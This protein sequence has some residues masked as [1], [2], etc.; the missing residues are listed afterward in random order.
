MTGALKRLTESKASLEAALR[1]VA[2]PSLGVSRARWLL[3]NVEPPAIIDAL[4]RGTLP[5]GLPDPTTEVTSQ[6]I[7]RW[8]TGLR[9][10]DAAQ[11]TAR[12]ADRCQVIIDAGHDAWPFAD[13]PDPPVLLFVRGRVELLTESRRV[14]VVGTRRCSAVGRSVAGEIGWTL[15]EHGISVVSGLALGIDGS[16]HRGAGVSPRDPG[17]IGVVASGLDMV[18]PARNAALWAGVAD[19]GVL[20]SETPMGERATRWRFPARNRLI[21]SLSEVIVVVESHQTG[22]A[23]ITVDE[24][25]ARG[26]EVVAVPGSVLGNSCKGSNQLLMDGVAP[27][28]N[29]GDVVSLLGLDPRALT[30]T[31]SEQ[32]LP[33]GG[34]AD[35]A[36]DVLEGRV[37]DA[38]QGG[39]TDTDTLAEIVGEPISSLLS[40]LGRLERAN[41]VKIDG[42]VVALPLGEGD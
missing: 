8:R 24:A 25:I 34:L 1:L 20:I 16:A 33:V 39:A 35:P 27:V 19:T 15:A 38:L 14:G 7:E 41:R 17:R 22:G 42:S 12:N 40:L 11:L 37:V 21:A 5:A 9:S 26:V 10:Q 30:E 29:G 28:R 13:D 2:L 31:D 3:G 18:Y 23:L 6:S 32:N 36:Q 4:L